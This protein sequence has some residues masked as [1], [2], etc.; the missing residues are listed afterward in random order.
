[1]PGRRSGRYVVPMSGG[2]QDRPQ[3]LILTYRKRGMTG[4]A[5]SANLVRTGLS[6]RTSRQAG[7]T[8]AAPEEDC[9]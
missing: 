7:R 4:T 6:H 8:V 3:D 9:T 1:M 5:R 2:H